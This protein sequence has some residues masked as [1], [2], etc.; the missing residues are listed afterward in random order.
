MQ[1]LILDFVKYVSFVFLCWQLY[2]PKDRVTKAHTGQYLTSCITE[3]LHDYGI[4]DKV[5][6]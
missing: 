3:T 2:L 1:S 6:S 5:N 4:D